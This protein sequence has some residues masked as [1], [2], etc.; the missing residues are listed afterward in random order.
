[1]KK[2]GADSHLARGPIYEPHVG[3]R[4][5]VDFSVFR[6][7]KKGCISRNRAEGALEGEFL[8]NSPPLLAVAI[9]ERHLNCWAQHPWLFFTFFV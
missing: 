7:Q 4:F 2:K 3:P 5:V 8:Q 1:M 6:P 9:S